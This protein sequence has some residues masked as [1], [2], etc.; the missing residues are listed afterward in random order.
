MCQLSRKTNAIKILNYGTDGYNISY[1]SSEVIVK[2]KDIDEKVL[3]DNKYLNGR[4]VKD[5]NSSMHLVKFVGINTY[6]NFIRKLNSLFEIYNRYSD[7]DISGDNI[8][9]YDIST[10][11]KF[12]HKNPNIKI[13]DIIKTI[14][15]LELPYTVSTLDTYLEVGL[16]SDNIRISFFKEPGD[17]PK[18]VFTS[19]RASTLS[20]Y[21]K[22]LHILASLFGIFK[23]GLNI[24]HENQRI[25][26][27]V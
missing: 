10:I 15:L 17:L 20:E 5:E 8:V 21:R 3:N 14:E 27:S 4:I 9:E 23:V 22:M 16:H 11:I 24:C 13:S 26:I 7:I 2:L 12:K 18:S 6:G 1:K 25:I 19:I